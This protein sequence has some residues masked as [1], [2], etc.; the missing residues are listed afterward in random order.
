MNTFYITMSDIDIVANDEF[1]QAV[2][3]RV[4]GVS[5]L[6]TVHF[7]IQHDRDDYVHAVETDL[8]TVSAN[9]L[10]NYDSSVS[11]VDEDGITYTLE[12]LVYELFSL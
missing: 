9:K 12:E 5:F 8:E 10:Q 4:E 7:S 3:E 2:N 11:F 1:L 6:K